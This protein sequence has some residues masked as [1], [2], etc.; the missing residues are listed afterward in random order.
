MDVKRA[1][2]NLNQSFHA[3]SVG[4]PN[5]NKSLNESHF[6]SIHAS[7]IH[8]AASGLRSLNA[9]EMMSQL[10]GADL[11]HLMTKVKEENEEKK[12]KERQQEEIEMNE[13]IMAAT[14][15]DQAANAT[16]KK[17]P[18]GGDNDQAEGDGD[19]PK[20]VGGGWLAKIRQEQLAREER[21]SKEK[22]ERTRRLKAILDSDSD[23][24]D[25]EN[26]DYKALVGDNL[27]GFLSKIESHVQAEQKILDAWTEK[28]D[29]KQ[30]KDKK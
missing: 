15:K 2:I 28:D 7:E 4:L 22:E 12:E 20:A 17:S 10:E 18:E 11:G 27:A 8:D 29:G 24:E 9:S 25:E 30:N 14:A 21:A 6:G 19:Q 16:A 26:F 23:A 3:E 1:S 5:A 13:A